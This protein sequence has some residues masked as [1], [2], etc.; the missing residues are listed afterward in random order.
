MCSS[1]DS[2]GCEKMTDR[3]DLYAHSWTTHICRI[4]ERDHCEP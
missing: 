4:G 3:K 2:M 1:S